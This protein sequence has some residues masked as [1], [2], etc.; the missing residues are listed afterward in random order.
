MVTGIHYLDGVP[1]I[2]DRLDFLHGIFWGISLFIIASIILAV[3][4][5]TFCFKSDK[6]PNKQQVRA[7]IPTSTIS[8]TIISVIAFVATRPSYAKSAAAEPT[9]CQTVKD[10]KFELNEYTIERKANIQI[11]RNKITNEESITRVNWISDCEY[12]LTNTTDSNDVTKVKIV[13]VT[14]KAYK[15]VA[16]SGD[17]T[18]TH[19]LMIRKNGN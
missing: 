4:I 8:L 6:M 12:E 16:V 9:L 2:D 17:R 3:L 11:E 15:C 19:E 13:S 7:F 1:K 5:A 14:G 18:T 10:G